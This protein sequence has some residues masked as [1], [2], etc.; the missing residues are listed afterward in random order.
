[1]I[2]ERHH[3]NTPFDRH[4]DIVSDYNRVANRV[5]NENNIPIND[6]HKIIQD[7]SPEI[8]IKKD[9]VHMTERGNQLLSTAVSQALQKYI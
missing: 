7:D 5:M 4:D 9:G 6:L 2:Y 3:A 8:C 1:V